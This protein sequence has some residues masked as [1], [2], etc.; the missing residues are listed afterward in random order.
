MCSPRGRP[1]GAALVAALGIGLIGA[2]AQQGRPP[3]G[4][5]D[6]RPPV[7]VVTYP[8]A[9]DTLRDLNAAVRFEFDERISERTSGGSMDDA[10]SI[11]PRAG[12]L[13]VKRGGRS[14][15]V[16]VE[17]GFQPGIVYRVTLQPVVLDLFG[18]R[19]VDPFDL[20][21]ST[22]GEAVPTTLAGQVWD[23]ITGQGLNAAV[24][25]AVGGDGLVHE[26][27]TNREGIFAFRYLP[28]GHLSVTAFEDVNRNGELDSL[29]V[30]GGVSVDISAGDT[31]LVDVAVLRPDTAAAVVGDADAIDSV[32]FV[33]VFDD[34][35]DPETPAAAI[36]VG[37]SR[38]GGSVP[39]IVRVFHE[40]EY[41]EYVDAVIDSF[42]RLDSIDA[43]EVALQAAAQA[44]RGAAQAD[45]LDQADST[46]AL[47]SVP[48]VDALPGVDSVRQAD[49][50]AGAPLDTVTIESSKGRIGRAAG[51]DQ[52]SPSAGDS[53]VP[54]TSLDRLQGERPGVTADGR[55][56][57]PGRRIVI[58]LAEP[59]VEEAE[60]EVQI[61]SVLNINGL[62]GGGGVTSL[63]LES[64]PPPD[65]TVVD[66]LA[67][68]DTVAVPDTGSVL[69]R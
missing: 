27:V 55:R 53:R 52:E 31:L 13:K 23:R 15:S 24:V 29:E 42:A 20:V 33:V 28:G 7:V 47:D 1:G 9:F 8:E 49:S 39:G 22:G 12:V 65:T 14:L 5:E 19:L 58:L 40:A 30:Q 50:L 68:T 44:A 36:D 67:V 51:P 48:S 10:I 57:L 54:P 43:A 66:T 32:T 69:S 26:S 56:V 59:L 16:E 38:E 34:F 41:A 45:S 4:P 21:F 35:L 6:L 64:P 60:Y 63:L 18:N 62:A 61:S 11:S 25:L 46:A 37:I 17:G 2:C 3:G